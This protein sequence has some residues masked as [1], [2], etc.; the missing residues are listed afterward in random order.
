M[1]NN[2]WEKLQLAQ[3]NCN[4]L[5]CHHP[6]LWIY[7]SWRC[8]DESLHWKAVT[9]DQ[10]LSDYECERLPDKS[11][12]N[13]LY[14]TWYLTVCCLID[15]FIPKFFN[16][17]NKLTIYSCTPL[18]LGE[19]GWHVV[20]D[21]ALFQVFVHLVHETARLL[22][23]LSSTS[24]FRWCSHWYCTCRPIN[25]TDWRLVRWR[26]RHVRLSHC[27][28]TWRHRAEEEK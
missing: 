10:S 13:S 23:A 15:W 7:R 9:V 16:Y 26:Q 21:F 18:T 24:Y 17:L 8:I 27:L 22:S 12:T 20:V 19:Y 1:F 14:F 25:S 11:L 28:V 2:T 3:P 5:T 6:N 4:R